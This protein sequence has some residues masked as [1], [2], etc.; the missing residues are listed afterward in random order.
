MLSAAL[1]VA[2]WDESGP[3]IYDIAP[4]GF[5]IQRRLATT[6]SGSIYIASWIDRNYRED[7]TLDEAV[8]F[9]VRGISHAVVRDGSCGGVVNLVIITK[10]GAM[11]RTARPSEQPVKEDGIKT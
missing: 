7:F 11:R 6:G 2:G 8:A 5:I 9:A 4:S 10:D 1:I 3:Q